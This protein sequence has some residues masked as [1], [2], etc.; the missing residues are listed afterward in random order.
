MQE[1]ANKPARHSGQDVKCNSNQRTMLFLREKAG[2]QRRGQN[3]CWKRNER[4]AQQQQQIGH[5]QAAVAV[6]HAGKYR[7]VVEL[8]NP[9]IEERCKKCEIVRPLRQQSL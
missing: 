7:A 9:D 2:L 3:G 1:S 8:N 5:V 6:A 4:R